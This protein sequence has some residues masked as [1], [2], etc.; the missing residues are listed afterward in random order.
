MKRIIQFIALLLFSTIAFAIP[1]G[2]ISLK[3]E[4]WK[5]S[6]THDE[7]RGTKIIYYHL[8]SGNKNT[9]ERFGLTIMIQ[10]DNIYLYFSSPNNYLP[11]SNCLNYCNITFKI[12]NWKIETANFQTAMIGN[13]VGYIYKNEEWKLIERIAISKQLIIE[14]PYKDNLKQVK[15]RTEGLLFKK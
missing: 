3:T 14:L 15:F 11:S 1:E 10:D 4:G 8:L 9:P 12:D 5:T 13:S 7:M 2:G 6:V